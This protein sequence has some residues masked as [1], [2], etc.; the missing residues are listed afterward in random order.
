MRTARDG[1]E[2]RLITLIRS[3][4]W[5]M[6]TLRLARSCALPDWYIGAGAIRDTVWDKLH[7]Y[8]TAVSCHDIDLVYFSDQRTEHDDDRG[9]ERRLH[10]L[11]PGLSWDV[12]NQARV[13]LW[14]EKHHGIP[15]RKFAS[16]EAGIATWPETAT[17]IGVRLTDEDDLLI[18]APFGLNDLFNLRLRWNAEL[19]T[20]AMF[21][22]RVEEKKFLTR[23]P[24][25]TLV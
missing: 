18:V 2:Q 7:G 11:T 10:A 16:S 22:A 15:L 6:A 20:Y 5:L 17:A 23:W 14:Y 19:V 12:T 21:L 25:L 9:L 24:K 3:T 4:D 13:H 8:A 1:L